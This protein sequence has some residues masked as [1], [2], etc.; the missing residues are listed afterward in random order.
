MKD[1]NWEGATFDTS[2][3]C[4]FDTSWR[5]TFNP[6]WHVMCDGEAGYIRGDKVGRKE[7][8]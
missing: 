3:G 2:S 1:F 5:C 6:D 7:E 4:I 8:D